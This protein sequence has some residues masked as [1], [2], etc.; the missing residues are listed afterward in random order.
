MNVLSFVVRP[1]LSPILA[2]AL[3]LHVRRR[4]LFCSAFSF[5]WF[6][7]CARLC[8]RRPPPRFH[9][10]IF[11]SSVYHH[12]YHP[13]R[14]SCG[15][16]Y[17]PHCRLF[18]C[19]LFSSSLIRGPPPPSH[20]VSLVFYRPGCSTFFL[21]DGLYH[22]PT[23]YNLITFP[24]QHQSYYNSEARFLFPPPPSSLHRRNRYSPPRALAMILAS[25][26]IVVHPL[27]FLGSGS[28]SRSFGG[29][30]IRCMCFRPCLPGLVFKGPFCFCSLYFSLRFTHPPP[31]SRADIYV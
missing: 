11:S 12:L 19:P 1:P 5:L 17:F 10:P 21:C 7:P 30:S 24:L 2:L 28:A 4:E 20:I 29:H 31:Y 26:T 14:T 27:T 23:P 13:C 16:L 22:E 3:N 6:A 15:N 8:W 18:L 9:H 25:Y